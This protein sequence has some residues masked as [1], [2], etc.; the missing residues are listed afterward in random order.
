MRSA[1]CGATRLLVRLKAAQQA[2]DEGA[3]EA[4]QQRQLVRQ[5][6]LLR[7]RC[8]QPALGVDLQHHLG[9][10]GG[11]GGAVDGGSDTAVQLGDVQKLLQRRVA[12]QLDGRA[13]VCLLLPFLLVM[14]AGG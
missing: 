10:R 6:A 9:A 13:R 5:L 2:H 3:A 1:L 14:L 11:A 7:G 4:A 12:R 8:E